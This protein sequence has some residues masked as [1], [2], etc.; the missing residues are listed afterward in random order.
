MS[1]KKLLLQD[2]LGD[3]RYEDVDIT[4]RGQDVTVRMRE[5]G[6]GEKVEFGAM[7][8]R[9]MSPEQRDELRDADG[10]ALEDVD[11]IMASES[12]RR[13]AVAL[14]LL[15]AHDPDTGER[16]FSATQ[17][18]RLEKSP[19]PWLLQLLAPAMRVNGQL[20]GIEEEADTGNG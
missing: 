5:L 6:M 7:L 12:T 10:D 11:A 8:E 17:L 3:I 2:A 1:L 9:L 18:E 16:L 15:S 20:A 19:A 4:V 13:Y 14:T